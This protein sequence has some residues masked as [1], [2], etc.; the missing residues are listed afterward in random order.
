MDATSIL[1]CILAA[2]LDT[3]T[4][5][6]FVREPGLTA[7]TCETA[8]P[9]EDCGGVPWPAGKVEL[10]MVL[11]SRA[12]RAQRPWKVRKVKSSPWA[13]PSVGPWAPTQ[14]GAW[15]SKPSAW[16]GSRGAWAPR[17]PGPWAPARQRRR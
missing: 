16:W 6:L 11:A 5:G 13:W 15:T 14:P 12:R 10:P 9:G 17:A 7:P 2:T 3:G 1:V 4:A 8:H